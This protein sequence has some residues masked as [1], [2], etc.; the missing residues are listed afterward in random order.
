MK[1]LAGKVYINLT[2][3]PVLALRGD[4]MDIPLENVV[5]PQS[6]HIAYVS[7]NRIIGLPQ[8]AENIIFV[9]GYEIFR[10]AKRGDLCISLEAEPYD[11]E[12][13]LKPWNPEQQGDPP[14]MMKPRK[15]RL[16]YNF[17][18]ALEGSDRYTVVNLTRS[19]INL[20]EYPPLVLKRQRYES[21]MPYVEGGQIV[22]LPPKSEEEN[23]K[24]LVEHSVAL[25]ALELGLNREDLCS[26]VLLAPYVRYR[27]QIRL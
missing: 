18:D 6:G 24:L 20:L 21:Y 23:V 1:D 4:N 25:R 9:V 2:A 10:K 3:N 13:I 12:I 17:Y 19:D 15:I 27:P 26:S 14:M 16:G 11:G 7:D 22:G 8:E 5:I